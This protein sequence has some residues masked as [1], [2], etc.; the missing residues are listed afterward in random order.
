MKKFLVAGLINI[1][2]TVS[3]NQFPIE[4]SPIDYRFFGVESTVSGVGYNVAKALTT[5]GAEASLLSLIGDDIYKN[6]IL[7]ELEKE[8]IDTTYIRADLDSIPQSVVLYDNEGKRKINLDLKDIQDRKYPID[9]IS[10][11]LKPMDMV[12]LCNINFSRSLLE[13]AK[14]AGKIIASDVHV[15]D[16]TE[17]DY[18]KDFMAYADILFMSNENI[19]GREKDFIQEVAEKFDNEI[20]VIGMGSEGALLY[21]KKDK[22][23]TRFEAVSTRKIVSTIGAGDALFTSFIYFYSKD[24]DPYTALKNAIVF[25][26]YKIGE[27]GAASGFLSE[28]ELL[29]I[30]KEGY[31][32]NE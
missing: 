15:V 1:E 6:L 2:T 30:T 4:Y 26:S 28:E 7:S 20:I 8:N 22:K 23:I 21:V 29:K 12:A 31:L 11:I 24:Q 18:N 14:R 5:L 10:E 27:K 3:V 17:D 19:L 32:S 13:E 16:N 9:D 25:A